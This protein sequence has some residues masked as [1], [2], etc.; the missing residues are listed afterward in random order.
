MATFST[1]N[2]RLAGI[3]AIFFDLDNT[4]IET[5]KAD[6]RTCRKLAEELTQEYGIP[7]EVSIKVTTT[8]LKLFRKC[9]DNITCTLDA[10]RMILWNKAL[11]EKFSYLAK[12][13]YERWLYL[14]YQ[15]LA[16]ESDTI[17]LLRRLRKKYL[18]GLITNGPSNA[19]WE[20][21][22][23]LSLEQYFDIILVSGDLPWEKPEAR[24]FE[25]AC[26]FLNV[27]PS[28]CIMIGDKLETDILGGIEAGFGATVW[29]PTIDKPRLSI[30]DP[31]PDFTVRRLMDI[32]NILNRK[33]GAPELEDTSSNASDGS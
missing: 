27:T 8:Y 15:Y 24:I 2:F 4:L 20:K 10:W 3:N 26:Q 11:G 5:R 18:L 25:E 9:P 6:S 28:N 17:L 7:E 13:I 23:K 30:E 1:K 16:L 29:I 12:K 32:S 19:Q 31:Q 21:V 14:R 22:R 33:P